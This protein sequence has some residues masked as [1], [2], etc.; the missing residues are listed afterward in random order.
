DH[1]DEREL[2]QLRSEPDPDELPIDQM[3]TQE[4]LILERAKAARRAADRLAFAQYDK[5]L[6]PFILAELEE[7]GRGA[8]AAAVQKERKEGLKYDAEIAA[9]NAAEALENIGGAGI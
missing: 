2:E 7:P 9:K 3:G 8:L 6:R 5:D 4:A 1:V